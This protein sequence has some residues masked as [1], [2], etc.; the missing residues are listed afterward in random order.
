MNV[1]LITTIANSIFSKKMTLSSSI[2]LRIKFSLKVIEY[3]EKN[4]S[5]K[6]ILQLNNN[7]NMFIERIKKKSKKLIK[8][9][10]V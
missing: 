2:V 1:L 7:I 8:Y 10:K 9:K 6:E 3:L 4:W 5:E